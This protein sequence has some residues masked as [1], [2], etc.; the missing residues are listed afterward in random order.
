MGFLDNSTNNLI[1]DAVLTD[2]GRQL[3][4]QANGSFNVKYYAFGDDEVDYRL[5]KRYGR[6]V[7]KEKIEKNTPIL[8]GITNPAV[9]L[10]YKLVGRETSGETSAAF[11]PILQTTSTPALVKNTQSSY[12]VTVDLY[13]NNSTGAAVPVEL[14]QPV[15][16]IAVSDRFFTITDSGMGRITAPAVGSSMINAGDPNRTVTYTYTVTNN[17]TSIS[18]VVTAKN[19][20]N[21]T[22]SVY[23]K[24]INSTSS[25]REI[26]SYIT[27]T[28]E[29]HGCTINIPVTYRASLTL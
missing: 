1:I 19:I 21:T 16:K 2:Y 20:D 23:G 14:I 8:E 11:M 3:L 17:S 6:T 10:K 5:I 28:G 24:R 29:R 9:A 27:V 13:Y 18:F 26:T 4:A 15:Y 12:T 22:L 7:G 25:T